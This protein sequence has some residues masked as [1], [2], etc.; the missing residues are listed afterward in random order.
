VVSRR[1]AR[2][3]ARAS[4]RIER[5]SEYRDSLQVVLELCAELE[6]VLAPTQRERWLALE[7]ALLEHSSRLYRAYFRAGLEY[8]RQCPAYDRSGAV[9]GAGS[10]GGGSLRVPSS[11]QL[12][13]LAAFARL[14]GLYR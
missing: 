5:T 12:E 10:G 11:V 2:Q 4:A 6:R 8:G 13:F 1:A 14:I 7:D 3:F 9:R